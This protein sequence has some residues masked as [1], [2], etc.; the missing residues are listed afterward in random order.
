MENTDESI[1]RLIEYYITKE[2]LIEILKENI[3]KEVNNHIQIEGYFNE[4]KKIWRWRDD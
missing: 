4:P 3:V 1:K 2:L